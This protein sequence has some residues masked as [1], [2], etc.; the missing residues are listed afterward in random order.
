MDRMEDAAAFLE[1][2]LAALDPRMTATPASR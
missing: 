1:S 2:L